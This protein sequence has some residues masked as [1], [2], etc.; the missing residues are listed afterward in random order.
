MSLASD[1]LDQAEMLAKLDKRKP[2]QANLRR[3]VSAAYYSVFHLLLEEGSKQ[4]V[5][6][7]NL[8]CLI[9]RSF[10]HGDM[11]AAAIPFSTGRALPVYVANA[12]PGSIPVEI[13]RIAQTFIDL[14]QARHEADYDLLKSLTR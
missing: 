4:F 3:A 8:R 1:L 6:D 5:A 9:S 11:K 2:K 7:E 12:F 13:K 10:S 14:Q